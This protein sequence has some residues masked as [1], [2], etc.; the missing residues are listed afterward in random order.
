LANAIQMLVK[1]YRFDKLLEFLEGEKE[2]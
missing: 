1:K 2:G